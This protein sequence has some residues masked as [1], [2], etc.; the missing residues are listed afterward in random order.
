MDNHLSVLRWDTISASNG[1][2]LNTCCD[3]PVGAGGANVVKL[4]LPITHRSSGRGPT[5]TTQDIANILLAARFT[6]P[7]LPSYRTSLPN[8]LAR[9]RSTAMTQICRTWPRTIDISF[10]IV[11]FIYWLA[12]S[13]KRWPLWCHTAPFHLPAPQGSCV[14]STPLTPL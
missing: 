2:C 4:C 3:L 9:F 7:H 13:N 10:A 5:V 14:S 8:Y 6:A 12:W 11:L 1:H